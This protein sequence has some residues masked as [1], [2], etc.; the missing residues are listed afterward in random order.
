MHTPHSRRNFLKSTT[1]AATGIA[2]LSHRAFA[3]AQGANDKIVL[4]LIGAGNMGAALAA[5]TIARGVLAF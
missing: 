1:L 2:A 5:G 3:Q 4:G